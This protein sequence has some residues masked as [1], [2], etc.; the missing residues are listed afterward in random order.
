MRTRIA[1]VVITIFYHFAFGGGWGWMGVAAWAAPHTH[2]HTHTH[3]QQWFRAS[4][5]AIDNCYRCRCR[6]RCAS[7]ALSSL[8]LSFYILIDR[9]FVD[10]FYCLSVIDELLFV[11]YF[12][13]F[14]SVAQAKATF[15]RVALFSFDFSLYFTIRYFLISIFRFIVAGAKSYRVTFRFVSIRFDSLWFGL[16]VRL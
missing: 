5:S 10:R 7:S 14:C 6:R 2:A 9:W 3:R 8:L 13:I 15:S 11:F 4:Q 16:T 1:W 12:Y